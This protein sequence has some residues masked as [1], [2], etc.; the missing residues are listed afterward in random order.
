ML[1]GSVGS[2]KNDPHMANFL[3]SHFAAIAAQ[4]QSRQNRTGFGVSFRMNGYQ[5]CV[6]SSAPIATWFEITG[7]ITATPPLIPNR[8]G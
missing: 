1:E 8:R 7:R 3:K 4:F 5:M 6:A 2:E